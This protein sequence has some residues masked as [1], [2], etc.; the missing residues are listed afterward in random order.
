MIATDT[1]RER[2]AELA[3]LSERFAVTSL[4]ILA[5]NHQV[6]VVDTEKDPDSVSRVRFGN[7]GVLEVRVL[8]GDFLPVDYWSSTDEVLDSV[9]LDG[10]HV[11][12]IKGLQ[13]KTD[14]VRDEADRGLQNTDASID[15]SLFDLEVQSPRGVGIDISRR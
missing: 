2:P 8:P 14:P 7:V 15:R 11:P 3:I 4:K 5:R 6:V 13:G 9:R 1:P 10:I 12:T